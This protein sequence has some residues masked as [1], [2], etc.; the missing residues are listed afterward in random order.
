MEWMSLSSLLLVLGQQVKSAG[1]SLSLTSVLQRKIVLFLLLL[2]VAVSAWK[3]ILTAASPRPGSAHA[4]ELASAALSRIVRVN[5]VESLTSF[6]TAGP[7]LY[8]N[9]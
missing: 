4:G 2:P 6:L 7:F 5:W 8:L 3:G 9:L 1:H